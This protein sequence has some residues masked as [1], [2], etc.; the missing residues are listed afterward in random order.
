[1]A[2][3][4]TSATND[5]FLNLCAGS[6]NFLERLSDKTRISISDYKECSVAV[7]ARWRVMF[8]FQ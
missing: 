2:C 1:M 5:K 6:E 7:H 3:L 8:Y 4:I